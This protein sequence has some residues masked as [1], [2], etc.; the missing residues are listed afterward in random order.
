V[1][2]VILLE[3]DG[4]RTEHTGREH[5]NAAIMPMATAPPLG[6]RSEVTASIVGQRKVLPQA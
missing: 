5:A 4:R 1:A 2:P 6:K 3:A